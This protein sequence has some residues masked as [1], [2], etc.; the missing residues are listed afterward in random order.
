MG[1][2]VRLV[3]FAIP[4]DD[5]PLKVE[6]SWRDTDPAAVRI[7]FLEAGQV[8]MVSRAVLAGYDASDPHGDFRLSE[9]G[10][11]VHLDFRS[12]DGRLT[13]SIVAGILDRFVMATYREVDEVIESTIIQRELEDWLANLQD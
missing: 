9:S 12:P 11:L 2:L 5:A 10:D 7:H 8:W 3:E 13:T 1:V 4:G 6:L